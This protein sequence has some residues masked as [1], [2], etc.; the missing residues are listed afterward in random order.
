M[1][2]GHDKHGHQ[3][4]GDMHSKQTK[5]SGNFLDPDLDKLFKVSA[6]F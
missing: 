4:N 6:L 3:K 2:N 5:Q 1:G